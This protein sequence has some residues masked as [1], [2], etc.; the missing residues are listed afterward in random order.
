M[1]FNQS[2][3]N[4][5]V[6]KRRKRVRLKKPVAEN[7]NG[8]SNL[9]KQSIATHPTLK[10]VTIALA[11]SLALAVLCGMPYNLPARLR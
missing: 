4:E 7:M 9:L 1:K 2:N 10:E 6:E 3:P 11:V 5:Q 8:K